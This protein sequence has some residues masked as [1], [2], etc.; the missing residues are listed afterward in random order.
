MSSGF[1]EREKTMEAKWAHDED[2]RF[3]VVTRRNKL[4]AQWAAEALGLKQAEADSYVA[5][6][7]ELEVRGADDEDLVRKIRGDFA[8]GNL[9]Y[10]EHFIRSRMEELA[11]MAKDQIMH[12]FL[13]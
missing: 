6:L 5:T 11:A 3:R 2:L 13:A 4:L 12:E 10:S 8:S 1:D 7:L 9:G